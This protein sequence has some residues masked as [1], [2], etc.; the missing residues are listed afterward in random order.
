MFMAQR[1]NIVKM[2][3]LPKL[4]QRFKVTQIKILEIFFLRIGKLKYINQRG[5]SE[6][7]QSEGCV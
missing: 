3:N 1:F 6:P 4:S 2:S 7:K 5:G